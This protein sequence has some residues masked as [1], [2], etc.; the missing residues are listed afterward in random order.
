M[1]KSII[2]VIGGTGLQGGGVVNALLAQGEFKVRVA[3]RNPASDA[4][5]ALAARDVEMVHADLLEPGSLVAAFEGAYCSFGVTNVGEPT[6]GAREE[7]I[8][9]AAVRAAREAGVEHLIW[10]TL[11]DAEKL[12]AGRRKVMH[13]SGKAHVDAVVRSA[14]FARHTFVQA[15]MYF[16]TFLAVMAPQPLPDGGRGW[17]VPLDPSKSVIHAGDISELVKA[18]ATDLS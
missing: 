4:A 17:A 1:A 7:E 15:P 5:R 13:F 14:G 6:Q 11:P 2:S 12:T 16:Q 9:A 10:S 18:V 3:T 8:G